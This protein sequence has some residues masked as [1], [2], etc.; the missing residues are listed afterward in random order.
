MKL[1]TLS[2]F[3]SILFI[4]ICHVYYMWQIY[5]SKIDKKCTYRGQFHQFKN[6]KWLYSKIETLGDQFTN[7]PNPKG[8]L[9][10]LAF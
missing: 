7:D 3:L 6:L 1:I 10:N 5:V 2:T 4:E 8:R 9:Y